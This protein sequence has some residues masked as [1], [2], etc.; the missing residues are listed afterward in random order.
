M[1]KIWWSAGLIV[2]VLLAASPAA[3]AESLA[4]QQPPEE[5]LELANLTSVSSLAAK[6]GTGLEQVTSVSQLSDVKP[7]DWAFQALQSLVERYGCIVGYPNK[8]YRGNRAL[9]R[10]EFAAGVNACLDRINEL[11][12]A[13]TVDLV[14]KEDL[15]A[16]QKLQ[17]EFAAELAALRGRVEALEARTAILEKQQFSMTTKLNGQLIFAAI[18]AFGGASRNGRDDN[19][20]TTLADRIRLNFN[21]SFTGK[22]LLITRIQATNVIDP[23]PATNTAPGNETRLSFQ[24]GSDASNAAFLSLLKYGFPIGDRVKAYVGTGSNIGF[25]DVLD[26]IVNPLANDAQAAISRFG[27]FS[28]I[29]RLGFDTGGALNI[30]LTKE[31]RLEAGYLAS[32]A[33][34]PIPGKGLFNGN[35]AALAQL[36]YAPKFA[37]IALTYTNAYSDNGLNHGTGSLLSNLSGRAISSNSY[38]I[39]ANFKV[40][41]GLQL[42]GWVAY[43]K[44]RAVTGVVRGDADVWTY[45]ATLA[46][47]DLFK[48]GSLGG[49]IVGMEPKLTGSD[50]LLSGLARRSDADTGLHIEAF[51][52]YSVNNNIS[53]TPGIIWLTA[54]NHNDSNDDILVGV[55]RTTFSF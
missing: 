51:Y 23:R 21:T 40:N 27:R 47:P 38:G 36:V 14:R 28:P 55:I 9:S 26:D 32:E 39:E 43:M 33:S 35:Y 50:R 48:K 25:I 22:D 46:F 49:I 45:A 10:Y 4:D 53:I 42:G 13:A 5:A 52:R 11:L 31:F 6:T 18:D 12:A 41:N 29:Y 1:S 16:L 37:T 8:T 24:S 34:S 3:F 7:T 17:E 15:I 19:D 2:P 20:N 54:P 30:T 44:A